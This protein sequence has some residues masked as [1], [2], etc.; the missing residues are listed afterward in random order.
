VAAGRGDV[1]D[2]GRVADGGLRGQPP[3]DLPLAS[4]TPYWWSLIV[5]DEV[6]HASDWSG[7][8]RFVT[9]VIGDWQARW[10][11]AEKGWPVAIAESRK[12]APVPGPKPMPLFR[13]DFTLGGPVEHAFLSIV[14]LGH[15]AVSVNGREA[16]A[17]ML[18]P[19]WTD[20]RKTVLY[21]TYDVTDLLRP[22][23]NAIGVM[24]GNGMYHVEGAEGRYKKFVGT[25]G[26]P[27]LLAQL[28]VVL[29]S[30]ERV[31][32]ASDGSWTTRPGPIVFSSIYGG[33]DH[34]ARREIAGW[35]RAGAPRDGW[36]PVL[37]VDGPEG[38]LRAQAIPPMTARTTY[39]AVAVTEP[40]PG[41]IV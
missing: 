14:G 13:R 29:A 17:S 27:R 2:S 23:A 5:W 3:H 8:E 40:R 24:L 41:V 18:D 34:D 32:V 35:D 38:R 16:H 1:W 7:P 6:G 11:A 26:Q 15:H 9:G 21:T 4:Q 20:Y 25:F 10:I 33:E 36:A 39:P 30:G 37:L 31:V 12:P 22:G 28:V 19:G